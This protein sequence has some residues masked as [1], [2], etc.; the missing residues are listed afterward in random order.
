MLKAHVKSL[1][2]LKILIDQYFD[3]AIIMEMSIFITWSY[4]K[5]SV[6]TNINVAL[7]GRR[8]QI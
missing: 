8:I 6:T 5:I 2:P 3:V 7:N 4:L 1:F